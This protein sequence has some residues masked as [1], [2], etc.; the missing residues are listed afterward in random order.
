MSGLGQQAPAAE[1]LQQLAAISEALTAQE[2]DGDVVFTPNDL[3]ARFEKAVNRCCL[4]A[5]QA[6]MDMHGA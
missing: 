4:G 1:H 6:C 3:Q 5:D 2:G